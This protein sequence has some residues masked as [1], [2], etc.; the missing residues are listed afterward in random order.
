MTE[1]ALSLESRDEFATL[2]TRIDERLGELV[3]AEN[4]PPEKLHRAIRYSLLAPGKRVRPIVTLLSADAFGARDPE[5]AVD[6]ACAI[7]MVHAASL[8]VDD[9]PFMDDADERRGRASSHRAFG[10]QTATLA[11]LALLNRS[12]GVL[13][14]ATS[15]DERVRTEL[16][17][18]LSRSL[19]D[20]GGAIAGQEEDLESP[21]GDFSLRELERMV[22]H[23]T[24]ALF[25][26]SAEI[27]ARIA[28]AKDEVIAAGR[29][30]GWNFG[31]C[32]QVLDDLADQPTA[33]G[34]AGDRS[35]EDKATFVNVLGV[36]RAWRAAE[37][38]A[39]S[40]VAA[41]DDVD[42][43]DSSLALLTRA[44]LES[45]QRDAGRNRTGGVPSGR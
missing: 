16:V 31:L 9:L 28:G 7:E 35:D 38:Y 29:D 41:L 42:L 11:S 37:E 4:T 33:D 26:A 25:V 17:R 6:P 43:A 3:P 45:R 44:M 22:R 18:I 15:V 5:I 12:F 40:A 36:D 34:V 13:A 24:S 2:R 1:P 20:T 39:A 27:G 8:I 19:G 14:D 23:K 30:F 21:G 10:V 32:F